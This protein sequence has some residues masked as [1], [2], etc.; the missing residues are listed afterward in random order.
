MRSIW[1]L[2]RTT[3]TEALRRRLSMVFML[4]LAVCLPLLALTVQGDGSLKGRA[5]TFL[6]YGAGLTQLLLSLLTVLLSAAIVRGDFDRRSL[7]ILLAKPLARWQYVLGRWLGVALLNALLLAL[8]MGGVY[9]LAQYVR[10][11]PTPIEQKKL[12]GQAVPDFDPQRQAVEDEVFAARVVRSA[13]AIKPDAA[14]AERMAQLE[15]EGTLETAIQEYVRQE[16]GKAAGQAP[17]QA[18]VE[19]MA[20]EPAM[21][22]KAVEEIRGFIRRQVSEQMLVLD[23][24]QGFELTFREMPPARP[25]ERLQLRYKPRLL[26]S[27]D[28]GAMQ[29]AWIVRH[30]EHGNIPYLERTD[31]TEAANTLELGGDLVGKDGTVVVYFLNHPANGIAAKVVPGDF[32]LMQRA[33]GFEANLLRGAGIMWL[34]LA[35]LSAVGILFALLLS[36]PLAC[37]CSLVV[38]LIALMG[39]FLLESTRI[40]PVGPAAGW[41]DHLLHWLVRGVLFLLPAFSKISAVDALVDGALIPGID[42]FREALTGA[43]L[44]AAAVLALGCVLLR[45]SELARVQV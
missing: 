42:L 21:H 10:A 33:G 30:P 16:L 8:C 27:N 13:E 29:V 31:S 36:F 3:L 7:Y 4:L 19:R 22:A 41:G 26:R 35:F 45:R 12:L 24:G 17:T 18:D 39:G 23:P 1:A 40:L 20:R 44:R 34:R 9:I 14:V 43:G 32:V 5:Q 15:Q 25:E 6:A 28:E 11:Q 37:L 2:A 38:F